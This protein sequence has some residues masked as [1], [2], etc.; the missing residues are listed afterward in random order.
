MTKISLEDRKAHAMRLRQ[1]GY[2]CAQ[3]VIMAFGDV[4]GL[5]IDTAARISS[6]LGAGLGCGELCGV[7]NAMAMA[8]GML[9]GPEAAS[10]APSMK[11]SKEL[12]NTFATSN[13]NRLRCSE[14]KGKPDV[15]PCNELVAQGVEILHNYFDEQ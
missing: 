6:G 14:L 12:L 9:H 8:Q 15:R 1:E 2:N 4:T 13:G 10:K 5:D 3:S 11:A 7:A